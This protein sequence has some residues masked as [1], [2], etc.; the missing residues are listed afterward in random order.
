MALRYSLLKERAG[1]WLSRPFSDEVYRLVVWGTMA[2]FVVLWCVHRWLSDDALLTFRE[3]L[4]FTEGHG[5]VWNWGER[6]QAFTHPAWFLLLAVAHVLSGGLLEPNVLKYSSLFASLALCLG[7]LWL[8]LR[9][10]I[11]LQ[12]GVVAVLLLALLSSQAFIDYTSSGLENPLSYFLVALICCRFFS[13]RCDDFFFLLCALL[14]LNRMDYALLLLPLC[15]YAW[16]S[17][18]YRVSVLAS[19]VSL[20]LLWLIFSTWYFGHPL[21]NTFLAKTNI[22]APSWNFIRQG[23]F[24]YIRTLTQDPVTLFVIFCIVV[25]GF[26]DVR[27]HRRFNRL[28]AVAAGCALYSLYLLWIGGDFMQ[29]RFFAVPF[30]F[31]LCGLVFFLVER[32]FRLDFTR[33]YFWKKGVGVVLLSF[34]LLSSVSLAQRFKEAFVYPEKRRDFVF[35]IAHERRFYLRDKIRNKLQSFQVSAPRLTKVRCCPGAQALRSD[36]NVY[37]VDSISLTSPYLSRIPGRWGRIGHMSRRIPI[38][39]EPWAVEENIPI[40]DLQTNAFFSDI[41][42]VVR[43]NL[44]SWNRV[45]KIAKINFHDYDMDNSSKGYKSQQRFS[46][47]YP[48]F[49]QKVSLADLVYISKKTWNNKGKERWPRYNVTQS[50]SIALER[51]KIRK[52][53]F[54]VTDIIEYSWS[55]YDGKKKVYEDSYKTDKRHSFHTFTLPRAIQADRLVLVV[56]K[57]GI[58]RRIA[59]PV[60]E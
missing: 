42:H 18:G 54:L 30:F 59:R 15:L 58:Y 25:V 16:R 23:F 13:G 37:I 3:I 44:F 9:D 41:R 36:G 33:R 57:G 24:Y 7:A 6:V 32:K 10:L 39:F 8:F 52:V 34:L 53:S 27:R 22:D 40:L 20:C 38:D 4:N 50:V 48:S 35:G 51:K 14:F 28:T 60:L 21:A 31:A 43:G 5:M 17:C 12:K 11:G 29:G 2:L 56:A 45:K 26:Y 46:R 55:L 19:A 49:Q 47:F 1:L